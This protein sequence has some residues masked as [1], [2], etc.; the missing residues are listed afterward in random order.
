MSESEHRI[1]FLEILDGLKFPVAKQEIILHAERRGA[2]E[3]ALDRLQAIP[4]DD[5]K[6]RADLLKNIDVIEDQEGS[7]NIWSSGDSSDILT[8]SEDPPDTEHDGAV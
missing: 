3:E 5:Y 7:E 6:T 2:S 8:S 4:D 1:N